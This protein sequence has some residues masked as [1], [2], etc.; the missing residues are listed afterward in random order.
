MGV[1]TH[2]QIDADLDRLMPNKALFN[3]SFRESFDALA[4]SDGATITMSLEQSGGGDLTMQLSDGVATLDCTPACTIALTA[5]SDSSPQGNY[6]YI[7][8]STKVLT[9]STT[10]FPTSAEHIKVGYF[11]APSATHV[12]AEGCYINQNWNDHLQDTNNQGHVLHIAEHLRRTGAVYFSGI[13]PNGTD[14]APASSYFHY[15]G[16][17]ESYFKATAGVVFQLHRHVTPAFD[18]SQASEDF[19]VVNWNGDNYRETSNIADIVADSAGVS[20]SN[21]YFNLFFFAVGNKTGEYAPFMCKLPSGGYVSQSSAENDVDGYDDLTLPREFA[22]ESSTGVPVCRMTLKWTGGT[23]TLTHISTVD[24]RGEGLVASGGASGGITNFADNQFTIFDEAD[25]TKILDFDVSGVTGGNTRTVAIP[26]E[27]TTLLTQTEVTDLT[28]GNAS[29]AHKHDHGGQDGL[30][31]DDHIR[32]FDKDGSKAATGDFDFAKYKAITMACDNGAT[33]PS[34]PATGQWF[35]HTPTGRKILYCYD[36]SSWPTSVII[37]FGSMTVYV[38]DTDGTDDM[39]GGT[40]VDSDAFKTVQYAVD[41]LPGLVGGDV[42]INVNNE[43]YNETVIIKGKSLTGNYTIKFSGILAS[44]ESGT[45]S[46]N[47]VTGTEATQGSG[48]DTGNFAGDSY[49]NLLLLEGGDSAYRII[50]SHTDDV[51]TIVGTFASQPQSGETWEVFDWGT[52]IDFIETGVGQKG[53]EIEN[54]KIA[55]PST[56]EYFRSKS[57][58]LMTKCQIS[59]GSGS[60]I[61]VESGTD[62]R[63]TRCFVDK[64]RMFVLGSDYISDG[65]KHLTGNSVAAIYLLST[66]T[67]LVRL[68]TVIDIDS[69]GRD[70]VRIIGSGVNGMFSPSADGWVRIRN[71]VNGLNISYGGGVQSKNTIQY[72][73]NTTDETIDGATFGWGF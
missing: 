28:D 64:M 11:F 2:P 29:T 63:T 39:D 46:A 66:G 10:T 65:D 41:A 1:R 53:I 26:D 57:S 23:T 50:D 62:L 22:L 7:P 20:L 49:A 37:S 38:D 40:A 24:L 5:G 12:Q 73:G 27:D 52:T 55:L 54:I 33:L 48:T 15:I 43:T 18:T 8:Q 72:S 71:A 69:A 36:G 32:Y 9:K 35:F 44:Q 21:K 60:T 67:G 17:T 30:T 31:D 58:I 6:I 51:I 34:A 3:G 42:I 45:W 19:H 47:G 61:W 14:Q 16:A 13:D 56:L 68:G 25:I 59:H 70:G 4:T